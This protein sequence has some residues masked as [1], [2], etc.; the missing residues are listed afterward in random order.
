MQKVL[1]A[2][3]DPDWQQFRVALKGMPTQEKLDQLLL[4][5]TFSDR[6]EA[7]AIRVDNYLKALCRGGQLYSG[8]SFETFLK[9]SGKLRIKRG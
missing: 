6:D 9:A 2:V 3:K 4:Y 7:A 1:A 5:W 8:E